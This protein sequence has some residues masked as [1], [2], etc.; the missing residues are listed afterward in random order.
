MF[1]K[2]S[3]LKGI[4]KNCEQ[5]HRRMKKTSITQDDK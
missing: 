2:L 4:L 3:E 1:N 5:T